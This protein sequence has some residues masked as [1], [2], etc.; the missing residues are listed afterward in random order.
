MSFL[1]RN[2]HPFVPNKDFPDVCL[3]IQLTETPTEFGTS[4]QHTFCCPSENEVAPSDMTIENQMKAGIPLRVSM[5][6]SGD[7]LEVVDSAGAFLGSIAFVPSTETSS[8]PT[9][10]PTSEPTPEPTPE[11]TN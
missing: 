11:P 2:A 6:S 4:L 1:P 7:S 9:P 8:E 3:D 5:A 10:E